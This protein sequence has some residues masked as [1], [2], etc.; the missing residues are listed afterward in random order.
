MCPPIYAAGIEPSANGQKSD[1]RKYPARANCTVPIVATA[2]L[3]IS[4]VG[5]ITVGVV[6]RND[7]TARYPDAPACPTAL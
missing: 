2:T 4:A 7:I 5:R 3:R 1:Q 6:P